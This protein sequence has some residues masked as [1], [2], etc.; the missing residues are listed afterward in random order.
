[1]IAQVTTRTAPRFIAV[2]QRIGARAV[3]VANDEPTLTCYVCRAGNHE[4]RTLAML[5]YTADGREDFGLH[6]R[7]HERPDYKAMKARLLS[8]RRF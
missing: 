6:R 1:M 2:P 5:V 3:L 4:P 8:A 7:C